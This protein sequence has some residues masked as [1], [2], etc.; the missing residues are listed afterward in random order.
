[1]EDSGSGVVPATPYTIVSCTGTLTGVF[2]LVNK[3]T[4]LALDAGFGSG[5]IDYGSGSGDNIRVQFVPESGTIPLLLMAGL[6]GLGMVL[7]RRQK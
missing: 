5:G 7:R 6:Y 3:N 4:S 2:C 1:M